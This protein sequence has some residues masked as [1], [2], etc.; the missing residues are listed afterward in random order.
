MRIT[1]V[2]VASANPE[3]SETH[4]MA[5]RHGQNKTGVL[6]CNHA[7]VMQLARCLK[8]KVP[9]QSLLLLKPRQSACNFLLVALF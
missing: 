1:K 7:K 3:P 4:E 5:E 2:G 8:R 6:L 9:G